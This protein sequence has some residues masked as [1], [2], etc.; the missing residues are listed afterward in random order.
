MRHLRIR[1]GDVSPL[2]CFQDANAL[3]ILSTE[4]YFSNRIRLLWTMSVSM[5]IFG[6]LWLQLFERVV[7]ARFWC[8]F[9]F[10]HPI[11]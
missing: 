9:E 4:L 1:T 5:F 3:K 10:M 2:S 6:Y 7:L 11:N 8:Y